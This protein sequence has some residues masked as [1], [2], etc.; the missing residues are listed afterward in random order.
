[1]SH[2]KCYVRKFVAVVTWN[3]VVRNIN[4]RLMKL[5]WIY[6]RINPRQNSDELQI[7]RRHFGCAATNLYA[8]KNTAHGAEVMMRKA[9]QSPVAQATMGMRHTP[10]VQPRHCNMAMCALL[11]AAD[12]SMP[13]SETRNCSDWMYTQNIS[14]DSLTFYIFMVQLT[15]HL[16]LCTV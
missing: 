1:M 8:K 5:Y 11:S 4:L 12:I 10:T 6:G 15:K 3:W 16:R 2:A 9:T 14:I 7:K 13:G